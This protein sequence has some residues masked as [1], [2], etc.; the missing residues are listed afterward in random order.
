MYSF[1]AMQIHKIEI[2]AELNNLPLMMSY[3]LESTN[4][5]TRDSGV[6][7][8]ILNVINYNEREDN[9][10]VLRDLMLILVNR[11]NV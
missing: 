6:P 3:N 7:G 1:L 2:Q 11:R 8:I 5:D 4:V 9:N 10:Y